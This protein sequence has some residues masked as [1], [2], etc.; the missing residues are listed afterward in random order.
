MDYGNNDSI[1]KTV[2][3]YALLKRYYCWNGVRI[4]VWEN[5]RLCLHK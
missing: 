4:N 1:F 5:C 3:I 2:L